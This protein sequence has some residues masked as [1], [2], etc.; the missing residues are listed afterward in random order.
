MP[1]RPGK[2][3]SYIVFLIAVLAF[4]IPTLLIERNILQHTDGNLTLPWDPA[5]TN[6]AVGKNLAF[7]G[8]WGLSK[9]VFQAASS[10]LL[11]PI[12]L[13]PFF[14]IAGPHLIIPLLVNGLAACVLL[15]KLQRELIRRGLSPL[16]QLAVLLLVVFCLPLPLLVVS[17][18]EYT[19][20][21]MLLV[22]FAIRLMRPAHWTLYLYGAFLVATRYE[23]L[24]IVAGAAAFLLYRKQPRVALL[25]FLAALAP[26]IVF[27]LVASSKGGSFIPAALLQIRNADVYLSMIIGTILIIALFA[28]PLPYRK[29]W[30]ACSVLGVIALIRTWSAL[31]G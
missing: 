24:L 26:A 5:F 3:T 23:G 4:L 12:I 10:S 18:M 16:G 2:I 31:A 21:L 9:Y 22:L 27:G 7:F 1:I 30:L 28:I 17:G 14:F 20:F 25:L 29:P 13:V 8:V 15:W 11:Y 6:V 19:L